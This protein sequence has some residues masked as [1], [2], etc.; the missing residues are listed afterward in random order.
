[1]MIKIEAF[2]CHHEHGSMTPQLITILTLVN[3]LGR[4]TGSF[5]IPKEKTASVQQQL[6]QIHLDFY[7]KRAPLSYKP[8]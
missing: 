2:V 3:S 1:M 4:S 5:T 8:P 7:K 6:P